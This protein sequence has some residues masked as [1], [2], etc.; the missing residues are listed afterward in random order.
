[1]KRKAKRNV[2]ASARTAAIDSDLPQAQ[3]PVRATETDIAL[4]QNLLPA[5]TA[6]ITLLVFLPVVNNGF[7]DLDNSP[8][9]NNLNYR[10][11]GWPQ[12]QWMFAGFHFGQYQPLAWMTLGFDHILWWA[13]PFGHHLTNL[14]LHL[15]NALLF[16]RVSLEL[17]SA[18]RSG[19]GD[20]DR[21]WAGV[22][23]GVAALAFSIHPLRVESVAWAAARGELVASAFFLLCLF[24]YLKAANSAPAVPG[25]PPRWKIISTGA[26]VLSLLASPIG[27]VLPVILLI[28]DS[29][30]L[31]RLAGPWSRFGPEAARLLREKTPYLIASVAYVVLVIFARDYQPTDSPA[32]RADFF[33]WT[34]HQ[35]A[36]PAFYLRKTI[37][38]VELSPAYELNGWYFALYGAASAIICAGVVIAR[39]TWPALTAAWLC[40]L[41][42]LLPSFRGE[43]PAEQM[44]ADRHTYLASLP[45]ALLIGVAVGQRGYAGTRRSLWSQP[46]IWGAAV[47][48]AS[49]GVFGILARS[50]VHVWRDSETLWRNAAAVS[51]T[52]RAYFHL[53]TLSEAQDNYED[54]IAFN[55]RA[56]EIDPLRWD[57][58]ERAAR[59]LFKQGKI[60]QAVEHYRVVVRS[61]PSAIDA[62]ESLATGLVNGGEVEEAVQHFQK[63]LELAPE[64]NEN[65]FK[66]GTILA[67]LGRL[68]EA[69]EVLTAAANADR[70]DGRIFLRL[71]QVLAA[72]GKLEDAVRYFREATRLRNEDA[73]AHE[74][75]GRGLLELGKKD[76]AAKHLQEALRIM[77]SSPAA[78]S[79]VS[80]P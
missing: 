51:P 26:F 58:H 27:L 80:P 8:L 46:R 21:A 4:G 78:A 3:T 23:A 30:P 72:Q 45:W 11:L 6:V 38:P 76:E 35:L 61:N 65:R 16:Y 18:W 43:F 57:A 33:T 24:A 41:A 74:S 34:L 64:R 52:S 10:G 32:D 49:L 19:A 44:L 14:L 68:G 13:D 39:G 66:L 55:R 31:G 25:Y 29:Y 1:M 73:E 75:L 67:V 79:N 28:I 42:L 47:S 5:F 59:L 53:A 48:I 20:H 63:L 71:G 56:V 77:R 60:A 15:G 22:A 69:L 40:Y 2:Q 36:A 7:V 37:L 12:L 70:K 50:Q 17:L 62:R 54:A 9:V